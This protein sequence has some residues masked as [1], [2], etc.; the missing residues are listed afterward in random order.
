MCAECCSARGEGRRGDVPMSCCLDVGKNT[1]TMTSGFGSQRAADSGPFELSAPPM[2]GSLPA[3][4]VV[5][6]LLALGA[7]LPLLLLSLVAVALYLCRRSRKS[8]SAVVDVEVPGGTAG[9]DAGD[10]CLGKRSTSPYCAADRTERPSTGDCGVGYRKRTAELDC[11]VEVLSANNPN[12]YFR[13]QPLTPSKLDPDRRFRTFDVVRLGASVGEPSASSSYR[14]RPPRE[15]DPTPPPPPPP[16]CDVTVTSLSRSDDAGDA[17]DNVAASAAGSA[18]GSQRL[19]T[20]DRAQSTTKSAL[21]L[22]E[23]QVLRYVITSP[24]TCG[25][26]NWILKSLELKR[27]CCRVAVQWYFSFEIHFSFSFYKFYKQSFLFFFYFLSNI[28]ISV[29]ISFASNHFY[30]YFFYSLSNSHFRL[31][32]LFVHEN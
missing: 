19:R 20:L 32:V 3:A 4:T 11:E 24:F 5:Y 30:I 23:E 1:T 18:L 6:I 7:L 16:S 14:R 21:Q 22:E 12:V 27:L 10:V 13:N 29:F 28:S 15:P 31:C 9:V 8:S 2:I 26:A 25:Y 17:S